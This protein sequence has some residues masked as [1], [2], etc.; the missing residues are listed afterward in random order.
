[1]LAW[2][3]LTEC[4]EQEGWSSYFSPLK[5]TE[6]VSLSIG[7]YYFYFCG[8]VAGSIQLFPWHLVQGLT[9]AILNAGSSAEPVSESKLWSVA[10]HPLL[11]DLQSGRRVDLSIRSLNTMFPKDKNLLSTRLVRLCS[12][13]TVLIE[14]RVR[15]Q[16]SD[17]HSVYSF[18]IQYL[19]A[20]LLCQFAQS[21]SF[22]LGLQRILNNSWS[23][24]FSIQ[25]AADTKDAIIHG[26]QNKSCRKSLCS[27]TG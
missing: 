16:R 13:R 20:T 5:A 27:Q 26:K 17:Y 8:E 22:V 9:Q 18:R 1:M 19:V 10:T 11:C 24:S 12:K 4:D 21:K 7:S 3:C 25:L 2:S 23:Y 14:T 6:C 15:P